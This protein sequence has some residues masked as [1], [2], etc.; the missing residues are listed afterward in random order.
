MKLIIVIFIIDFN[1]IL[2]V[3]LAKF[4]KIETDLNS[5]AFDSSHFSLRD[6]MEFKFKTSFTCD[7]ILYYNYY[8]QYDR[9]YKIFEAPL[10]VLSSK[11]KI[12]H[13]NK[14]KYDI[15]YFTIIKNAE[16]L[17][18]LTGKYLLMKYNCTGR[19]EIENINPNLSIA[20]IVLIVFGCILIVVIAIIIVVCCIKKKCKNYNNDNNNNNNI[21]NVQSI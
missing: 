1:L 9:I 10:Y 4:D 17:N 12:E 18:G 5:I 7:N 2:S 8:D 15:K 13:K 16:D 3:I 14:Q 11:E 6:K 20:I 21:V 19:V